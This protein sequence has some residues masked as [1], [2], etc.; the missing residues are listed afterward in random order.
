M[1]TITSLSASQLRAAAELKDKIHSLETQLSQLLGSVTKP[2][3]K[4]AVTKAVKIPSTRKKPVISAAVIAKIRAAQKARWA[5]IK[6]AQPAKAAEKVKV[7]KPAKTGS[8]KMSAGAK[9]KLSAKMK[10]LWA[11]RKAAKK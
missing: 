3:A 9:A 2:A 1:S 4:S 7:A 10:A 11:A 8:K 6:E 5:K